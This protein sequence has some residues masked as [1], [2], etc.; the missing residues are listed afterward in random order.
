M[1]RYS[2]SMAD[3]TMV[4]HCVQIRLMMSTYIEAIRKYDMDTF[5]CIRC[6]EFMDVIIMIL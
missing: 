2:G 1:G 5:I 6:G 4:F 3:K